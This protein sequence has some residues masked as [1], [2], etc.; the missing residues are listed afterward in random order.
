MIVAVFFPHRLIVVIMG[1]FPPVAVLI[2]EVRGGYLLPCE[3]C[4][5]SM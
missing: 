4:A 1:G 3:W 5:L 2:M